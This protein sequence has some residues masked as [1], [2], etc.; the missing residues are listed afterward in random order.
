LAENQRL[1]VSL[2]LPAHGE[3]FTNVEQR[4]A[5]LKEHHRERLNVMKR[6]ASRGATAY[7]VCL[8][9]FGNRLSL[10]EM[11]FALTETLAHLVYLEKRG[12][13]RVNRENTV[14]EYLI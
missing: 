10:H 14:Y 8:E 6:I 13:L 11:R 7:Q 4:L 9:V 5:E 3:C 1:K 12:E 2:A